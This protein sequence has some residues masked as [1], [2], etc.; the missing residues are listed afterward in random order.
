MGKGAFLH[1]EKH[2]RQAC[3]AAGPA[4]D[5][6]GCWAAKLDDVRCGDSAGNFKEFLDLE[7]LWG[8]L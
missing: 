7:L 5:W 4:L 8:L 3:V 1:C 2:A 6:A